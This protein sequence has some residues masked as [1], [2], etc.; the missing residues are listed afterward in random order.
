MRNSNNNKNGPRFLDL[1][2]DMKS[3][4][5]YVRTTGAGSNRLYSLSG[6]SSGYTKLVN[7]WS[8]WVDNNQNPFDSKNP[9]DD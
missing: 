7:G 2:D 9:F 6:F 4:N 5:I 1:F 3:K 8:D